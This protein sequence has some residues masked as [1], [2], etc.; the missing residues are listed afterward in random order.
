MQ[1]SRTR[2]KMGHSEMQWLPSPLRPTFRKRPQATHRELNADDLRF[3]TD[4]QIT[5][6]SP[7]YRTRLATPPQL[8]T[9]FEEKKLRTRRCEIL[10]PAP[11]STLKFSATYCPR[12]LGALGV[13]GLPIIWQHEHLENFAIL[14]RWNERY[15]NMTRALPRAQV[16]GMRHY[17]LKLYRE[18]FARGELR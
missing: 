12:A 2:Q 6:P 17:A 5:S 15:I 11:H 3:G 7:I 8:D 18:A 9:I 16:E 4:R 14:A 1:T 10:D 13:S